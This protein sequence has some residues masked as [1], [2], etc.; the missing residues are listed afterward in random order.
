MQFQYSTEP[1]DARYLA[2]DRPNAMLTLTGSNT[3]IGYDLTDL[4]RIT[5]LFQSPIDAQYMTTGKTYVLSNYFQ[6]ST[7]IARAQDQENATITGFQSVY[8]ATEIT[9][10]RSAVYPI[11]PFPS[12]PIDEFSDATMDV[13]ITYDGFDDYDKLEIL[14]PTIIGAYLPFSRDNCTLISRHCCRDMRALYTTAGRLTVKAAKAYPLGNERKLMDFTLTFRS[15][16]ISSGYDATTSGY[17]ANKFVNM[18]KDG[19]WKFPA[20]LVLSN[21]KSAEIVK[22]GGGG[23]NPA[24]VVSFLFFSIIAVILLVGCLKTDEDGMKASE[25]FANLMASVRMKEDKEQPYYSS[26]S[27]LGFLQ[28]S[29]Y[30]LESEL[31]RLQVERD[32]V[33]ELIRLNQAGQS[34][35]TNYQRQL[36]QHRENDYRAQ[37]AS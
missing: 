31:S 6:N 37:Q 8:V 16:G 1:F 34:A 18:V 33:Q 36:R 26:L 15:S 13:K 32:V 24:E 10:S 5:I 7:L 22:S 21:I 28:I 4:T 35:L 12:C 25:H 19:F 27:Y 14:L 23:V 3:I 9:C 17:L 30:E 11:P 29:I 20:E 2:L